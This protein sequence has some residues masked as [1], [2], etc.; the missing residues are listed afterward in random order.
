MKKWSL[1]SFLLF[2]TTFLS[3]QF[4]LTLGTARSSVPQWRILTDNYIT[5]G[6]QDFLKYGTTA[7]L[8]YVFPFYHG[9]LEL[10]PSIHALRITSTLA[11]FDNGFAHDFEL[12]GIGIHI[13]F[14]VYPIKILK[15]KNQDT[16][17]Q[18]NAPSGWFLQMEAGLDVTYLKY[19][20]PRFLLDG[21]RV[22]FFTV[23]TANSAPRIG[24]HTGY[25]IR[26]SKL[27]S[28]TPLVGLVYYPKIRWKDLTS[29]VTEEA[30][31]GNFDDTDLKQ[32]SLGVRIGFN[33]K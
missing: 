30:L 24:L 29:I 20:Y 3:A 31:V 27:L 32:F 21:E 2:S 7:G 11:H 10:Q 26:L 23:T 13:K 28:F 6:K 1:F 14:N 15:L 25:T 17:T 33:L 12:N 8:D 22:E 9:T 19:I 5:K 4:G 18:T 16:E